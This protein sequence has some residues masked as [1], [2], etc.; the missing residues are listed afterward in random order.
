MGD[1]AK[2]FKNPLLREFF[3]AG[4]SDLSFIAIP[5]M[6]AWMTAGNAGYPIGGTP[7]LIGLVLD[8]YASLGGKIRCG[9]KVEKI[10]VDNG[11][12]AGVVL[13]DG[14]RLAADIVV[15]AADGHA[16]LFDM[17]EGKYTSDK[18]K[19][20]YETFQRF[21]SYIQVSLGLAA[22]L[23]GE[24]GYF[25][26]SL[27]REIVLD[28]QTKTS[29][30]SVRIFNFDPTFAPAGKTAVIVF[31]TTENDGYWRTLRDADRPKYEDEKAR[32]ARETIAALENRFPAARGKVE[33]VDVATPATVVR[34]TGNW[35]GSMEGWLMTPAT[36]IRSLP[37]VLPG[38]RDFYMVGQ[39]VS[40]GGGLPSGLMTGRAVSRKICRDHHRPWKPR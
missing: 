7:K 6:L 24:P 9:A 8:R 40:P 13:D 1:F 32:I 11:R 16:T 30:L 25:Y 26:T 28:P 3:G 33:V 27:D 14:Q 17:L 22:D 20:T 29:S 19:K 23:K 4:L 2:K 38:L 37:S 5:F 36:G 18:F 15:S 31:F 34:Y 21:P 10:I 35:R 12:A 39:W